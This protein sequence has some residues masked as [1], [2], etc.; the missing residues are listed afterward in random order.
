[1]GNPNISN[2]FILKFK[3]IENQSGKDH[4]KPSTIVYKNVHFQMSDILKSNSQKYWY[5]YWYLW[6]TNDLSLSFSM[7][8]DEKAV[9]QALY[10][11]H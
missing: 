1:M 11:M 10:E 8:I 7:T 9:S 5:E 2:N 3:N 4:I 6:E